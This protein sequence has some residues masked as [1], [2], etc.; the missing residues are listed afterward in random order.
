MQRNVG[1]GMFKSC[2]SLFCILLVAGYHCGRWPCPIQPNLD[3]AR[4]GR[5]PGELL[6]NQVSF[7][8]LYML[9]GGPERV[10]II[11]QPIPVLRLDRNVFNESLQ[12]FQCTTAHWRDCQQ[13]RG[14]VWRTHGFKSLEVVV[15]LPDVLLIR[16]TTNVCVMTHFGHW[17][18]IS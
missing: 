9:S 18:H 6:C 2:L 16:H 15:T 7:F 11:Y 3:A 1:M 13:S 5:H 8:L 14:L 17:K 12:F 10:I 4:L